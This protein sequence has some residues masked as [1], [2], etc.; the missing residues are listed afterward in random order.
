MLSDEAVAALTGNTELGDHTDPRFLAL[1]TAQELAIDM[2]GSIAYTE[3]MGRSH[4]MVSLP[5]ADESPGLR[6]PTERARTGA[7]GATD[8]T[9]GPDLSF[10]TTV[11][12]RPERPTAGMRFN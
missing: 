3:A 1:M 2:D 4:V 6:P 9:Q 12:L 10:A 8:P 11:D 5:A 7:Y